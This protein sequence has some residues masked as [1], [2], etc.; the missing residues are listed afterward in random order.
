MTDRY[1]GRPESAGE[2]G[3]DPIAELLHLAGPRPELPP[4]AFEQLYRETKGAWRDKA[5]EMR[6]ARH[7][8]RVRQR[9]RRLLLWAAVV[10][11]AVGLG[12]LLIGRDGLLAGGTTE[13]SAVETATVLAVYGADPSSI[14]APAEATTLAEAQILYTGDVVTTNGEQRV[15]LALAGGAV[16]RL[17]RA[18]VLELASSRDL[19]L[20]AGALYVDAGPDAESLAVRTP[21]GIARDI[22]TRFEA[23]LRGDGL[24]VLVREGMVA[25]DQGA[26]IHEAGAGQALTVDSRGAVTRGAIAPD[27]PAWAWLLDAASPFELEGATLEALLDWV[28]RET[29]WRI[30]YQDAALEQMARST[31]VHGSIVGVRPNEAPALVLPGSGLDYDVQDG[32]LRVKRLD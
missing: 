13:T 6:A 24:R 22:G 3:Q 14:S 30:A 21:F 26:D 28:S 31:I 17:D 10:V 5:E 23:R 18:S 27:D 4:P 11:T 19:T 15:V 25:V 9:N 7:R 16:V 8:Q 32:R 2:D 1:E 12:W 29:G 20:A